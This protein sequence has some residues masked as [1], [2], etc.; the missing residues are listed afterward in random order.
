M[1]SHSC[2]SS[3]FEHLLRPLPAS[4]EQV[5]RPILFLL[6]SPVKRHFDTIRPVEFRGFNKG[7]PV[8]HY[9]WT[10]ECKE[11]PKNSSELESYYGD[12][13]AYLMQKHALHNVYITNFVKCS[14]R[15]KRDARLKTECFN[16]YLRKELEYFKPA[17]VFCFG[18]NADDALEAHAR[19]T[20]RHHLLYH[21][22]AIYYWWR[23]TSKTPLTRQQRFDEN[24]RRIREALSQHGTRT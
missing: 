13:F 21:P 3:D 10:P 5:N 4:P 23:T 15:G 20:F 7:V 16:R 14:K 6:D 1:I 17:I 24:D 18:E 8:Q 11:W 9:Y 19:D 2:D 12:Y 22:S